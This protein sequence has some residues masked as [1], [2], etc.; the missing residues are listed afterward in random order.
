[1]NEQHDGLPLAG[2]RILVVGASGGIGGAIVEMLGRRGVQLL[3]SSYD[4]ERLARLC[5]RWTSDGLEIVEA[6]PCDLTDPASIKTA[7][8]AVSADGVVFA[9]GVGASGRPIGG[10]TREEIDATLMINAAAPVYVLNAMLPGLVLAPFADVVLI[11]STVALYPTGGALYGASKSATHMLACNL[12]LELEDESVRVIEV[13][14][15]R[16]RTDL[17][18]R[19]RGD[20]G[21]QEILRRASE[22]LDPDDVANCVSFALSMPRHVQVN[23]LEV[24]PSNQILGGSRMSKTPDKKIIR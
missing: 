3:V 4:G 12:R 23:V 24:V 20:D 17:F 21:A 13:A 11:G 18:R 16:V 1:M 7:F 8:G 10:C 2:R 5:D 6:I 9:A 14:P 22:F 19:A 15:G